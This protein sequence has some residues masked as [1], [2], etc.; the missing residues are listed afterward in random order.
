MQVT[1]KDTQA[2]IAGVLT[3]KLH[4]KYKNRTDL[5]SV[6]LCMRDFQHLKT[7]FG[8]YYNLLNSINS[9]RPLISQY[10]KYSEKMNLSNLEKGGIDEFMIGY[11][12]NI[13]ST[14]NLRYKI[15]SNYLIDE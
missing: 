3:A 11:V 15:I 10:E 13:K 8:R 9:Y 12:D 2:Y 7:V 14:V 4:S 5:P 1:Y 6:L